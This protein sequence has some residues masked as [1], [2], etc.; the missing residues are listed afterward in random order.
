MKLSIHAPVHA[1]LAA[2]T[3]L[4]EGVHA[5]DTTRCDE[6]DWGCGRG[7]GTAPYWNETCVSSDCCCAEDPFRL[8]SCTNF[9]SEI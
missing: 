2:I 1:A 9:E 7:T 5:I 8:E 4:P 3:L 6:G